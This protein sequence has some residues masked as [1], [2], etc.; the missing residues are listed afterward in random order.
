MDFISP[1]IAHMDFTEFMREAMR[2]A[3]VFGQKDDVPIGAV[4]V[5][6]GKIVSRG[7]S[8]RKK[9]ANQLRHAELNALLEGGQPLWEIT[10]ARSW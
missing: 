2:E 3:E 10:S 8:A 5:I 7:R 1:D 6:D 4:V 9:Y